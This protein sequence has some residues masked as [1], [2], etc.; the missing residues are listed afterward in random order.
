MRVLDSSFLNGQVASRYKIEDK[1]DQEILL[2]YMWGH[3][4][5]NFKHHVMVWKR[6]S[7]L[8]ESICT[9]QN[10]SSKARKRKRRDKQN[11]FGFEDLE[12]S[13]SCNNVND[14]VEVR[15]SAHGGM[16]LYAKIFFVAGQRI[17]AETAFLS[18]VGITEMNG[19]P[20]KDWSDSRTTLDLNCE[21]SSTIR[22]AVDELDIEER[23]IFWDF[24]QAAC[25]GSDKTAPGIFHTNY[26]DVSPV[27]GQEVGCMYRYISRI[28]H[29]C[30]PNV[31]WTYCNESNQ[32]VIIAIS[33][34]RPGDELLVDYCGH[35]DSWQGTERKDHLTLFYDFQCR[36][37]ICDGN[38]PGRIVDSPNK[39]E[40]K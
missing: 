38:V 11:I 12:K 9:S 3:Y 18:I 1:I 34:I 15:M 33:D 7:D 10:Q 4:L 16:G 17:F 31:L 23:E 37:Q 19:N 20:H 27:T 28:N 25:Y 5:L 35:D 13:K 6:I 8:G 24:S 22:D 14:V 40:Q 26:I 21:A 32:L 36:C 30:Q 39:C 2:L 29:S